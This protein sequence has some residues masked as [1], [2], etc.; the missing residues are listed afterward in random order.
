MTMDE[1]LS[2]DLA[3]YWR[4]RKIYGGPMVYRN[5]NDIVFSFRKEDNE[6][7]FARV[8]CSREEEQELFHRLRHALEEAGLIL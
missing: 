1:F 4:W 5:G 6:R 3:I 8:R 2:M 7:M